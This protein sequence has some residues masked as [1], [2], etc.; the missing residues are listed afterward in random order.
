MTPGG[1]ARNMSEAAAKLGVPNL[2]IA[3]VAS[4][5][6]GQLIRAS[7]PTQDG[8]I[9]GNGRS[10]AC[11]FLL[12]STGDLVAGVA[13]MDLAGHLDSD[14]VSHGHSH[15]SCRLTWTKVLTK[16]KEAHPSVLAF[17][18]NLSSELIGK[19]AAYVEARSKTSD[20]AICKSH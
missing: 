6:I 1:V 20:P 13:D 5:P 9:I 2:L 18:G 16:V 19:L 15:N 3:G 4:D 8:L 17:D 14:V 12:G 10:S 7:C 11:S